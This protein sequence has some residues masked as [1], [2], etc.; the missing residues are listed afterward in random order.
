MKSRRDAAPVSVWCGNYRFG[1]DDSF[2][3]R[4]VTVARKYVDKEPEQRPPED[5]FRR[6]MEILRGIAPRDGGALLDQLEHRWEHPLCS[7]ALYVMTCTLRAPDRGALV[8]PGDHVVQELLCTKVG[9]ARRSVAARI[10]L[11]RTQVL[12]GVRIA[13][14]SQNLRVV[15][16]GDGCT[17]LLEREVKEVA[18]NIG[19]RAQVVDEAG[20]RRYVG[21][22]AYVGVEMIDAICSLAR[23]RERT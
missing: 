11:Y 17:M 3:P 14:G 21:S 16:Y 13:K 9:Q 22:E 2:F 19:L 12:G 8:A 18:G 6:E 20:V 5:R 15:I 23:Q 4:V 7:A 1:R 10:A